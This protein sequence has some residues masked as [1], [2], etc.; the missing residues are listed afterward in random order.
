MGHIYNTP[1]RHK[2]KI[3]HLDF[4]YAIVLDYYNRTR[5]DVLAHNLVD[6]MLARQVLKYLVLGLILLHREIIF[7]GDTKPWNIVECGI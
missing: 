5:D 1:V 7:H 6:L 2:D 3:S 4:G